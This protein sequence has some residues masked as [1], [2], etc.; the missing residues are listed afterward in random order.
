MAMT[1]RNLVQVDRG[2]RFCY[3]SKT[4]GAIRELGVVASPRLKTGWIKREPQANWVYELVANVS[5]GLRVDSPII[6]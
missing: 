4:L 6:D 5:L 1:A 3:V 2:R